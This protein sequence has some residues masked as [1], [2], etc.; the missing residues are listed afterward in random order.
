M[1]H[2]EFKPDT[3]LEG[4]F[5][6]V[7]DQMQLHIFMHRN[8]RDFDFVVKERDAAIAIQGAS[9]AQAENICGG[10]IE[11]GTILVI[12]RERPRLAEFE[13]ATKRSQT[14][15]GSDIPKKNG[16]VLLGTHPG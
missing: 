11:L 8:M 12:K 6:E 4:V 15:P 3:D 2:F 9:L 1:D 7:R 5:G 13:S 10:P 14:Q 16:C